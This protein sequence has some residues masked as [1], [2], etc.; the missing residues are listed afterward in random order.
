MKT[1]RKGGK[2]F[3]ISLEKAVSPVVQENVVPNK[4]GEQRQRRQRWQKRIKSKK[5]L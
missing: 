3:S 1:E 5:R 2:F 4:K